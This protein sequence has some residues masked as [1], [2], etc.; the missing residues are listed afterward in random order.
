MI[1]DVSMWPEGSFALPQSV[2]DCPLTDKFHWVK[3]QVS[4]KVT[5]SHSLQY[6]LRGP[7]GP[8][9]L[10]IHFCSKLEQFVTFD[11]KRK[12][13]AWPKGNYCLFKISDECPQGE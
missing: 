11:I 4:L 13:P 1:S 10:T 7:Y 6:H 9:H 3:G 2:Y 5:N 12:T 8:N